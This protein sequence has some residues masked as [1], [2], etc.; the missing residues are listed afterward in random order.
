[1]QIDPPA[2]WLNRPCPVCDQGSCLVLVACPNC[3]A[4][5]VV[6]DEEGSVFP[7]PRNLDPISALG[8]EDPCPSC[9]KVAANAFVLATS[10]QIT[11]AGFVWGEYA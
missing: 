10:D 9:G 11:E 2:W 7:D 6:C 8:A 3:R 4:I 5:I 1:M